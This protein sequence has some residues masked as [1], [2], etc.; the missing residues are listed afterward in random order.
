M[1]VAEI[2]TAKNVETPARTKTAMGNL[3]P[4]PLPMLIKDLAAACSNQYY[5]LV[6]VDV[7]KEDG[8]AVVDDDVDAHVSELRFRNPDKYFW[9]I[10]IYLTSTEVKHT[11]AVTF[12]PT[13]T[14]KIPNVDPTC[15]CAILIQSI[16]PHF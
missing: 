2:N 9:F 14:Q 13:P 5:G 1:E 4:A 15:L 16:A 8:K 6:V 10:Y 11:P 3:E 7:V 12:H